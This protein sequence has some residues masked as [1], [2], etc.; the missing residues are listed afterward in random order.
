VLPKV[1]VSS[2]NVCG[3]ANDSDVL[4]LHGVTAR[5]V[6]CG[7]NRIFVPVDGG[8]GDTFCCTSCDAAVF[9]VEVLDNTGQSRRSA[10]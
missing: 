2:G 9:L 10:A 7:G 1:S 5:C 3:M 8:N 6:D 4:M